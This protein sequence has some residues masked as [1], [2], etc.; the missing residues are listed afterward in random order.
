M[1]FDVIIGNPP[2]QLSDG[3][4]G[5]SAAPIF[6]HFVEGLLSGY[7]MV[8]K[9][10]FGV[11]RANHKK[12]LSFINSRTWLKFVVVLALPQEMMN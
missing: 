7:I 12:L 1:K 10:Y 8:N 2:Y 9:K 6:Q 3:G 4:N 11:K 5:V